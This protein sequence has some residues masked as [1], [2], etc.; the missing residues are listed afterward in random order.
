MKEFILSQ[1]FMIVPG[2]VLIAA[3]VCSC[4]WMPHWLR[5]NIDYKHSRVLEIFY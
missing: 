5:L 3:T 2:T 4:R 1:N